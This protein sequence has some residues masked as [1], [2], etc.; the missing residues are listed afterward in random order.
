MAE[1]GNSSSTKGFEPWK[2]EEE[3]MRESVCAES[4]PRCGVARKYIECILSANS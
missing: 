4:A 3:R 2:N 1:L